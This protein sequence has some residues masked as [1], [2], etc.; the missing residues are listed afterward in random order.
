M[1][2]GE[3]RGT[4]EQERKPTQKTP[5]ETANGVVSATGLKPEPHISGGECSVSRQQT[6]NLEVLN[7]TLRILMASNN[8]SGQLS[9]VKESCGVSLLNIY[10]FNWT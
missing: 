8:H 4:L 9:G 6:R 7:M 5:T 3:N 2:K 10:S 1:R